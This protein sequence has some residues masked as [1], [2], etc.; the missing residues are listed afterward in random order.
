MAGKVSRPHPAR[1]L[2]CCAVRKPT[3]G[4][5]IGRG[6]RVVPGV[7]RL[8]L[9]LPFPGVPHCNAWALSGGGGIVLV[10]T[11]MHGPGSIVDLER[12]LWQAG[13]TVAD[14]R[15]IVITHA[16][17]DHSGQAPV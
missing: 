3:R 15:L 8:R 6:E 5:D 1:S 2:A 12:A 17:V 13:W 9:P 14:V 11:G 7:W 10:D 16:H 4:R